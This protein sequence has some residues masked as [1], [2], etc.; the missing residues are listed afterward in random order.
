MCAAK[1]PHLLND[2][3]YW[4]IRRVQAFHLQDMREH[5]SMRMK[6]CIFRVVCVCELIV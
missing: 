6:V 4:A 5:D 3:G 1:V 2:C